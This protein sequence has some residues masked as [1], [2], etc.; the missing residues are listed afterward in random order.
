[1]PIV[2]NSSQK[3]QTLEEFYQ[4]KVNNQSSN[5]DIETGKAML[6]FITMINETFVDTT[7][8]GLTSLYRLIIQ[9]T[10]DWKDDWYIMVYSIDDGKFEF[11]YKV[12]KVKSP[13]DNAIIK[14]QANSLEEARDFLI[15]AM[16]ESDGWA[17]NK[18]LRKLYNKLK[19]QKTEKPKFTLWLEFEEVN[20]NNWNIEN[21]FCNIHVDL[22]DGRHYGLTVWTYQFLE[23]II[24]LNRKSGENLYGLYQ[25]PPDLFVKELTRD[26]IEQTI[27]DLLKID[28]LERVLNPSIL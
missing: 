27:E 14:G 8:Y 12:T 5:F 18:E 25:K 10:D 24:N 6:H 20:L 7:L 15:I 16:T 13:W 4:E 11:E 2:R 23:T 9:Q 3:S 17:D 19:N 28:D 21:G 22:E 26:C 1:M